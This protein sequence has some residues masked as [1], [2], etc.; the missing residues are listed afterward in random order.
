MEQVQERSGILQQFGEWIAFVNDLNNRNEE[1]WEIREEGKMS[2]REIV[3]HIMRWDE[4]FY[5]HAIA[6]IV[7]GQPLTVQ[8]LNFDE[9]NREAA[10]Y[11]HTIPLDQ[12]VRETLQ[13]RQN[14]IDAIAEM[15]EEEY[16]QSYVDGD[17]N[18]FSTPQ[19]LQDFLWHDRHHME[20]MRGLLDKGEQ[21]TTC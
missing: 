4:Y 15:S 3:S 1:V 10:A 12:L 21:E 14:V 11:A 13:C 9:F 17:G 20:P 19:Y 6:K 16:L 7:Q 18:P 5:Q 8:H 2:I